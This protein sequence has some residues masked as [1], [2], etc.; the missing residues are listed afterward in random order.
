MRVEVFMATELL[1]RGQFRVLRSTGASVATPSS[2]TE[3]IGIELG[4]GSEG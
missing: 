1:G 2:S 4:D 3:E